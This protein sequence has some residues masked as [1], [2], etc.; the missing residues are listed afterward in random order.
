MVPDFIFRFIL[1]LC[2][3][4]EIMASSS[5][6][7]SS[8]AYVHAKCAITVTFDQP[9][10]TV[11]NEIQGRI[12]SEH[13][14]DPHNQ[15]TYSLDGTAEKQIHVSRLTGDKM[16]TD[17]MAMEF[18]DNTKTSGCTMRACSVSQVTSVLDFSTN[19]CNLRNLYC[20]SNV[21]GCPVVN[22]EL[23][24]E[25]RYNNCWQRTVA[26]CISSKQ[27]SDL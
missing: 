11:R 17:K 6:C 26:K 13:W 5:V 16:F 12:Q 19:Y 3:L 22:H 9:C 2:A 8:S 27:K 4:S 10:D 24:Y 14:V 23:S 21:D 15:G 20:N 25:E 18:E 7:P 1:I